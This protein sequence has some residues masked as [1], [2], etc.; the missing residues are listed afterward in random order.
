[1]IKKILVTGILLIVFGV[2]L[3]Y[4]D[5][6][7]KTYYDYFV[8]ETRE[9]KLSSNEKNKYYRDYDFLYVQ[10]TTNF[11]PKNEQDLLNIIYTVLNHYFHWIYD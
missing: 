4:K 7:L 5:Q 9:V 1:M 10:N 6:I 2:T 11:K 8:K 3:L